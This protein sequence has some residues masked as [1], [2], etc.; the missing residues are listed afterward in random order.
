[1]AELKKSIGTFGVFSIA[2]GAMISSGIF[3]LPGLAFAKTGPALFLSYLLAGCMGLLGMLSM[4]ELTTAMPKAGGDYF[5]INKTFGPLMGTVS[6]ILGW[7]ALSLKSSF[8]VYGIAEI[9]EIYTGITPV[10]SGLFLC[11]LFAAVNIKGAGEAA[12]F[13]ISMVVALILLIS[14][15]VISGIPHIHREYFKT[16]GHADIMA[17]FKTA[18]FVFI[19]FG[20][21]LK[22]ANM[23]E[24]V[25]DPR[26]NLPAG[27]IGSV[28]VVTV[29][30]V[31]MVLV[32]TGTLTGSFFSRSRTPAADSARITMGNAGYISVLIASGLAFFTTANAG[33]M[34]ASRYPMAL[35]ADSLMPS[36]FGKI[37]P[38]TGTPV[39]SI[40]VTSVLIYLALLLPLEILVEAA[41]TVILSS[42]ILTNLSVIIFRESRITNYTPSFK[43]PFYP[44]L[45]IVSIVIFTIF[46]SGMGISA[47]AMSLLLLAA[48]M[49]VYVM[50]GR[51]RAR[52]ESA[53]LHLFKKVA[54]ELLVAETLEDDLREIIIDRD[55]IEQDI[56][57]KLLKKAPILDIT[58]PA[59]FKTMA[60]DISVE[61]S[62]TLDVSPEEIKSKLM[63]WKSQASDTVNDFLAIPHICTGGSGKMFL[64]VVRAKDGIYV[65]ETCRTVKA[66]FILACSQDMRIHHLKMIAA[67]ASLSEQ[68][69]FKKQWIEAE[70]ITNLRNYL[71]LN[72]RKRYF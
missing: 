45:Q 52:K 3:I 51:H 59:D 40:L 31:A 50:Y 68:H 10:L 41:S 28:L 33:V 36:A 64:Y 53:L 12:R 13:Q 18:G 35:S 25:K 39:L 20:G 71:I 72:E 61:M 27:F 47:T 43:T 22:A 67:V 57:D 65:N 58:G 7:V 32:M 11:V 5:I 23:S 54:D 9:I 15:Y 42:Y 1:M 24:E 66:M 17:V 56:F 21:L 16:A 6:G 30:Y 49:S 34:A 63:L 55:H 69:S 70:N 14:V 44:W 19:S 26:R 29:L 2:S 46:I 37:N 38:H 60:G 48:G 62:E 4:L 8:A